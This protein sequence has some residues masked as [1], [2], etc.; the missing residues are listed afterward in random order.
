MAVQTQRTLKFQLKKKSETCVAI[1]FYFYSWLFSLEQKKKRTTIK[2]NKTRANVW[3]KRYLIGLLI[4]PA[5]YV[6]TFIQEPWGQCLR[7]ST[8][9]NRFNYRLSNI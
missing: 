4:L 1:F 8:L 5:P 7:V 6:Y 3:R 9:Y 2:Y